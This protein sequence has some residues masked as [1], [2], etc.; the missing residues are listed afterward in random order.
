M[1]APHSALRTEHLPDLLAR[2]RQ[3]DRAAADELIRRVAP[4]LE[5][6]ARQMLRRFPAVRGQQQTADVVQEASLR[7][8]NA[9]RAITPE[10]TAHFFNLASL[11]VRRYLL[12][13][14][15]QFR[16]G[17]PLPLHEQPE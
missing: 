7:L 11:N 9:L 14:A 13:L 4:R 3:G 1:P 10:S 16:Q 15:R 2:W 17:M 5:V 12:E 8:L 6:L